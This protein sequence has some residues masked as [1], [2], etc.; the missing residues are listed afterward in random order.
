MSV[1]SLVLKLWSKTVLMVYV[2]WGGEG[3]ARQTRETSILSVFE[4]IFKIP[5]GYV[6]LF[7]LPFL[8]SKNAI[9]STP[10]HPVLVARNSG[11]TPP[12]HPH[13][14]AHFALYTYPKV[15]IFCGIN[16]CGINFCDLKV[17]R[18]AFLR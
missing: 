17:F 3:V 12:T 11:P 10:T 5:S 1:K 13:L 16:F 2:L 18:N 15:I 7:S 4:E 8:S 6:H 14:S 9:K